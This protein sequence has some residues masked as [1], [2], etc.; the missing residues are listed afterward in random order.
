MHELAMMGAEVV[1]KLTTP[2]VEEGPFFNRLA[3]T[4][5]LPQI[6]AR[7]SGRPLVFSG[8]QLA[9]AALGSMH[10]VS[11]VNEWQ[12]PYFCGYAATPWWRVH[13]EDGIV[14][15]GL[16]RDV[17]L[18]DYGAVKSHD[19]AILDDRGW[20]GDYIMRAIGDIETI[21]LVRDSDDTNAISWSSNP[22]HMLRR[23]VFGRVWKGRGIQRI[24]LRLIFQFP[25]SSPTF[26]SNT[27]PWRS[28]QREVGS[29]GGYRAANATHLG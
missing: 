24:L 6:S 26:I 16:C 19:S 20:D 3:E 10:S 5:I 22:T 4:G 21:Y 11:I 8:W 1:L 23:H 13:G 9:F 15:Y 17:L 27:R 29:G 18:I 12:A 2:S 25:T 28:S 14:V 7:D